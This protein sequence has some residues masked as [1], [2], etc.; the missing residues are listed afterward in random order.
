MNNNGIIIVVH[1]HTHKVVGSSNAAFE[2]LLV[3]H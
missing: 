2:L 3:A 1:Q